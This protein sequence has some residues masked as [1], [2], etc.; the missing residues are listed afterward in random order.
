MIQ[1]ENIF[2]VFKTTSNNGLNTD[3]DFD[4]FNF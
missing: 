1:Y 2:K 4:N 3:L